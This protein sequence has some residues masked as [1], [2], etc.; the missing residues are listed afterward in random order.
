MALIKRATV[1]RKNLQLKDP[2]R[3]ASSG[4]VTQLEEVYL[5][6]ETSDGYTGYGEVRGNCGYTTGDSAESIV[7][8]LEKY[9]LPVII[10]KELNLNSV[11][12]ELEKAVVGNNAAKAL[13][14]VAL[15]DLVGKTYDIPVFSML[16]GKV[17]DLLP[18]ERNIPFCS[19]E[20]TKNL[21]RRYLDSGCR[22]IKIR[23]GLASFED[24]A[25]RVAVVREMVS[26]QNLASKVEL[27][28]DANQAWSTKEAVRK[29]EQL[30]K[31]GITLVEQPIPASSPVAQL[32]FV[33]NS[34]GL[35]VIADESARTLNDVALLAEGRAVDGIHIKL[36]KCGGIRNA[37]RMMHVAEAHSLSYM[38]GG[39]DEGMMAV[40]AAVQC[41]AVANTTLF[42]L[43][44]HVR[45]EGD[46]TSGVEIIGGSIRV[47][48]GPGL[49]VT[50]RES[51]LVKVA[52]LES[53]S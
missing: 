3:H 18:S 15:H 27:G 9:L 51:E 21:T 36:S 40:A 8:T 17:N 53:H 25:A 13:C 49:G 46:P 1:F 48:Q 12:N 39:M 35:E 6:L 23:V 14:D 7:A 30:S 4:S 47:P 45:I 22:F 33:R 34:T 26:E 20:E 52:Q 19:L 37:L 42:E 44:N 29:I 24:D 41:A 31:Y 28:I 16:G 10:N 38:I 32:R 11:L 5:K 2:F 50:I 43:F